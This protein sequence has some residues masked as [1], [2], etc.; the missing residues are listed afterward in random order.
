MGLAGRVQVI[1][2]VNPVL[3]PGLRCNAPLL[4][5]NLFL[6]RRLDFHPFLVDS[7]L[8]TASPRM[9][10][11]QTDRRHFEGQI[12][13]ARPIV[14]LLALLATFEQPP[15]RSVRHAA[16]FLIAYL[17]VSF[18]II[19]LQKLLRERGWHLPLICD[20]VAFVAFLFI[21]PASVAIWFPYLFLCY[22][23]GSRWGLSAA[24]PFA[25]VLSLALIVRT[26]L[27]GEIGWMR[28]VAWLGLVVATFTAGAGIA[29]LGDL[30][31]RFAA[32][33][34]F[35]SRITDTMQVDQGLA[36][37][38]RQ[39]LQ[40][41]AT[42][43]RTGEALLLYRDA[44][45]ER[46]FLWRLK[47]GESERLVPESIPI[48]RADDFLLDDMDAALCWNSLQGSGSGF[49]WDRRDGHTLKS[50]PRL[51]GPTQQQFNLQN[52]VSVAFDQRG[53]PSGRI[54]LVNGRKSFEK[55]DLAWLERIA[56]HVSSSLENIF[57]L[58]HLRARAIEAER[59]RISRDLHDGILQTLL[60]IEI[61]IDVLRRKVTA[62]PEQAV[63]NLANLQQTVKN[64]SAELRHMVTDL[65]PLRVQS[66]DLLDLMQ[67]FAER[68]RN[69]STIALDILIDSAEIHAP[70]RV[71]RELFQIYREAL[72]NIKKHA[73]ASHVVVKL[74]QDDSSLVLVVD[75]NGEGFSFA[76][77]FTGD[78]LD[79]LRL[80]PI[81]IKERT[82][83]VGGILTVESNPGHGARLIVEIPL[84]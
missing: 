14:V 84:G 52:F 66:A 13:Y 49:G 4:A 73:K 9:S 11:H 3:I 12:V 5:E 62:S 67:G 71:C 45:L 20:I 58:R 28:I 2:T 35:L 39:F 56:S 69:E 48:A 44:D 54:F 26:A 31:R 22:A 64:E 34:E 65:R 63:N 70:D 74:S 76:G 68:Y 25:G 1:N 81:S 79:R 10:P 41:L 46:I 15:S 55:A 23:A 29:L 38:L 83:T 19:G 80:G 37:S 7:H 61:Q 36:E 78:E 59:S 8:G 50:L 53:V 17:F 27:Q 51:P 16:S 30:S 6:P 72:N 24:I 47:T 21:S 60:S 18:A 77:R 32:E 33:N 42:A 82:R 75:D 43:F 40:E 57:L